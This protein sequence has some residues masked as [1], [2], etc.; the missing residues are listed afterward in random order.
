MLRKEG[1]GRKVKERMSRKDG[2]KVKDGRN[3]C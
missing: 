1:Q 2:R 3:E